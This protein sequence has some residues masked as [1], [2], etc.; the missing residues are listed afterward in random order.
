MLQG[1][2][3]CGAVLRMARTHLQLHGPLCGD[4]AHTIKQSPVSRQ[5][6]HGALQ[7]SMHFPANYEQDLARHVVQLLR[8]Q[9]WRLRG[10]VQF[11]QTPP[12]QQANYVSHLAGSGSTKQ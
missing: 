9:S 3:L 7:F 12:P 6:G 5:R 10:N 1:S 11:I 8:Q 2:S 4:D